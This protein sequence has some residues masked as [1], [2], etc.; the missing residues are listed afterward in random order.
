MNQLIFD[1]AERGYPGFD[2]FL[3]TENAELVYVLQ[4]KHD[5]FIYVWGEEGAGKSHLLRAWVAQALDAGKKAVYIDAAATPLTEAAF[6]AEYLAIDQ[7][8]KLGN[9]EQ[10]LLFAVFNRFRNS[11]KGF[12]LLS[13]EHTPQQLVIREDLR[14]RMAYCLVYEVK[15]LT[16][17][18]KIDALVS[19]AAARQVTIDPEIFEYLL[20]HWRRDMDSLMQMLDTLDNYAVTMGKRITLPLLRQLLKQQ[21]TQ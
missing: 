9:E 7:I 15:P 20:N 16:D 13:S 8:E 17:Q 5:P 6:E 1:F 10:A 12:L 21:E 14:T 4:H 18:E 19:M 3:G 11:G 2:K